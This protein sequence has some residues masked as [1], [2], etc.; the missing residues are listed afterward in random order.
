MLDL[1]F[2]VIAFAVIETLHTQISSLF[3]GKDGTALAYQVSGDYMRWLGYFFIFMG[4]KM[5]TDGVLRGLGIM[6]PFLIA[7][8]VNLAIRLSVALL[9]APRFGIAFVWACRPGR[10]AC[11]LPGLL[12]GAQKIVANG[13][14][15]RH[16]ND[17]VQR[18]SGGGLLESSGLSVWWSIPEGHC[19]AA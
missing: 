11:K 14:L 7:N 15:R 10:V 18:G 17:F 1:C 9:C 2:A 12:C 13:K 4:I 3:L 8:M 19:T 6:R 16:L 5:A